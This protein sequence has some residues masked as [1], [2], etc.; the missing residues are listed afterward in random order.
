M[1]AIFGHGY[2]SGVTALEILG[3][4]ML[5][6]AGTGTN[7]IALLMAGGNTENLL[8]AAISLVINVGL[9]VL[10]IP[11]LGASGAALAWTVSILWTSVATALLLYRRTRLAPFGPGYV[12][13]II[14]TLAG[15]GL[16]AMPIRLL[17][18]SG[19][20]GTVLGGLTGTVVFVA[21]LWSLRS[22]LRLDDMRRL[23]LT[24]SEKRPRHG[25]AHRGPL[26]RRIRCP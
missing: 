6:N 2:A 4:A 20:I 1:M 18:G 11:H 26:P 8:I 19:V 3:V 24:P 21:I 17:V 9:N 15:Y 7:A 14:A 10:L 13:V 22:R 16:V 5:V 12:A 23:L 25:P